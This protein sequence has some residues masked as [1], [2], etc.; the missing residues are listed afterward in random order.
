MRYTHTNL[1]SKRAAVEKLAA[2]GDNLV[3]V[4]TK[5][6]HWKS[7]LSP[8]APRR[9]ELKTEEWPSG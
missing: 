8:N 9:L 1:D 3:T 2:L 6:Q 4:R 5:M 7:N